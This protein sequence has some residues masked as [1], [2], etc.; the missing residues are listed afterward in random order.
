M[1]AGKLAHY[2]AAPPPA[3]PKTCT[4]A[5]PCQD[6]PDMVQRWKAATGHIHGSPVFWTGPSGKSWLYVMGEGDHLKAFPFVNGKFDLTGTRESK[7]APPKPGP[8]PCGGPLDNWMPGGI[9]SVSSDGAAAG[10]GIVWVLVP[11][12]GDAN[13]YR[14]VKGMLLALGA[15]DV[16]KELWRSQ[17][18]DPARSDTADSLGLLTRFAPPTVANGKVFVG[19]AGDKEPLKRWCGARPAQFPQNYALVV[20]GLKQ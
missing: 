17:G 12:N 4:P 20:Y 18:I 11:S 13:S 1:K 3:N 8:Q 2:Q 16:S 7:W 5:P 10:T 19:N 6:G 15:E 9:I 14:G